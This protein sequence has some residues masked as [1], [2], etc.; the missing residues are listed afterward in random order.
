M[1][2]AEDGGAT[3]NGAFS[4]Y[5]GGGAG[6]KFRKKPFRKPATPY[7]R[8]TT[9]LR[10]S[11]I[12]NNNNNNSSNSSSSWL[13][14]LVVEPAS[15]LISYGADRF[16]GSV[17]RARLPPLP[18]PQPREVDNVS[19]A[20]Q[21]ADLNRVQGADLNRVQGADLNRV[22]GVDL[23]RVQGADLNRV[24]WVDLNRVQG[25][26][27][28]GQDGAQE[29][30][31]GDC[32]QPLNSSSSNTV[33]ELEHLLKQKTFTRSEILHLTELLQSR[34]VERPDGDASLKNEEAASDF[35]RHQ[36]F[37]SVLLE[38]NSNGGIRS[39]AVM[40]TPIPKSKALEYGV[41]SPAELA[42]SYMGSMPSKVSP[43]VL[44]MRGQVARKDMRGD[45]PFF[46]KSPTTSLSKKTSTPLAAPENGFL[47]P[48]ARGRSAIY[49]MARTPYSRVN[50]AL[51]HKGSGIN[52][53]GYARLS[54]SSSSVD[55]VEN[56]EKFESQQMTLKRRSSVLDEEVGSVGPMRRIRQKP[57]L[58]APRIHHTAHGVGIGSHAKQKLV[59]E[60]ENEN[61]SRTSYAHVPSQSSAVAS[62]ILEQ[63]EKL[64]P[65]EKVS[66][67]KIV[68]VREKSPLKLASTM[69]SGQTLRSMENV[70]SSKLQLDVQDAHN[71]LGDKTNANV[72]DSRDSS[73]RKQGKVEENGHRESAVPSDMWNP[74]MNNDSSPS[75]KASRPIIRSTDSVLT[76]DTSQPPQKKKSFRMTAQEQDDDV[77]SNWLASRPSYEEK[78]SMESPPKDSKSAPS[79]EPK[80]V[81]ITTQSEDK[82]PSSLTSSKTELSRGAVTFGE[83]TSF[84]A[85]SALEETRAASKSAGF[86][87]PAAPSDGP[88]ETNDSPPLFSFSSKVVDK[89]PSMPFESVKNP[90]AK[91]DISSSLVNVTAS[92]VSP[93][94]VL[95]SDKGFHVNPLKAGDI[96]GKS[97]FAPSAA[98]NGPL[99]S[100]PPRVS[101]T[102]ASHNDVSN[103][104]PA[105]ASTTSAI[106][107]GSIF[108]FAAKP[109]DPSGPVFK[110]GASVDL[111]NA[112]SPASTANV[113][114]VADPNTKLKIDAG[115]GTSSSPHSNLTP[116]GAASS[117]NSTFGFGASS[118]FAN[119]S[120][121]PVSG[122]ETASQGASVQ[123]D[124]SAP[125]PLPS[126]SMSSSTPF[127]SSLSNSQVSN[128][129][130]IFGFSSAP[131][132]DTSKLVPASGPSPS[133]FKF[134]AS[135]TPASEGTAPS[136]SSGAAPGMFGFG[137]GASSSANAVDSSSGAATPQTVT[138]TTSS[139]SN[140]TSGIFNFGASSSAPSTISSNST[141]NLFGSS[142]QNPNPPTTFGSTFASS[143]PATGFSFNA[144]STP[145]VSTNPVFSFTT[146]SASV[147]SSPSQNLFGNAPS[148]AFAAVSPG[149]ND[150]MSAEDSMAE[151]PVQQ[152]TPSVSVFGQ[153][154]LSPSP[155]GFTF[156]STVAS[157]CNP[158]PFGGQQ[159]LQNPSPFQ[160]SGSAEFNAGGGFSLG[161]GGVDKSGRKILRIGRSKN[162]KK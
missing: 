104:V 65:K 40:S 17:F 131:T 37:A 39:S 147:L 111:P 103:F 106:S 77:H 80:V 94:K 91:L 62:R 158:F 50:P 44:G 22:Q 118:I 82:S 96:N 136:L 84:S 41:D 117:G 137:F 27:L 113:N 138:N 1:S 31:G 75:L 151:D 38:E 43:S 146:A 79:E 29:T 135:S 114:E 130:G 99:V 26:D 63:L 11:S 34:A 54:M 68:A 74:A 55:L 160:T 123:L 148:T 125:A 76:N 83:G 108:G 5:S 142:W 59:V 95:A 45:I 127:G 98:S 10:G 25:A 90:E 126:F 120:K 28:N 133:L 67:S 149:S 139:Y 46:S 58:L 87:L 116:F 12:S 33:F 8:P 101:T 85:F 71:K 49:S 122:A 159:N 42:K 102:A 88:K 16:F 154:S 48:R 2:T 100:N 24:Q 47:T 9:V 86:S 66:E 107:S 61:V 112:A 128:P 15:K 89:L 129:N 14:K 143:S 78:K 162:R 23:N 157:Q 105:V 3:A 92:T 109:T 141:P 6:G 81:K 124:S 32:S 4:S 150:R 20:V 145:S 119:T 51:N 155:P 57:N 30:A 56:D 21:G 144:S 18:P 161:S 115:Y 134:G 73:S 13:K 7:D 97:D 140:G 69:F 35:G 36:Q 156:G 19:D 72:D 121:S 70:G 110:F 153:P 93:T 152:S 52:S 60:N 64:T 53:N 132:S